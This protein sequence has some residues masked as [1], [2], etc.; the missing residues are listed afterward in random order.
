MKWLLWLYPTEW[1]R[2]YRDEFLAL[3]EDRGL[4]LPVVLDILRGALDSR[5][6]PDL[7]VAPVPAN[8]P[9]ALAAQRGTNP[10]D[11]FT[12]R[13][14]HVLRLAEL[15]SER[16]HHASIGTEHLLLGLLLERDGVAAHVLAEFGMNPD[17]IRGEITSRLSRA[18]PG[19][20]GQVGLTAGA[21]R[22]I[23]LGVVEAN[24]LRHRFFGTEHLLLGMVA[25]GDGL[26]P[27][28]LQRRG[29]ADVNDLRR[30][31]L[32]LL[33]EGPSISPPGAL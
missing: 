32:R 25:A 24:R 7:S 13:S 27:E 28:L 5:L 22:A 11:R 3:I 17:D 16:L 6:H 12:K 18:G 19:Q 21:R 15:E 31:V 8:P 10:F 33:N 20:R 30:R 26:V 4:S 14:R 2:R 23:E 29:A 9:S 1:R